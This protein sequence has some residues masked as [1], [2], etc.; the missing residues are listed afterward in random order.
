MYSENSEISTRHRLDSVSKQFVMYLGYFSI[1]PLEDGLVKIC[2]FT[3]LS[4]GSFRQI[5]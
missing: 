3:V 2:K 5:L 4:S 1:S